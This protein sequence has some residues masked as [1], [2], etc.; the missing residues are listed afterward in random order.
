MIEECIDCAI[1]LEKIKDRNITITLCGHNFHSSCCLEWAFRGNLNCPLCIQPFFES[2]YNN[3]LYN[4]TFTDNSNNETIT[5]S[6]YKKI[7]NDK[8]Y[9]ISNDNDAKVFFT[10]FNDDDFN[11]LDLIGYYDFNSE[12]IIY[13]YDVTRHVV[14]NKI[15]LITNEGDV[16]HYRTH[17][18]IGKYHNIP[19]DEILNILSNSDF[20][21]IIYEENPYFDKECNDSEDFV[22]AGFFYFKGQAYRIDDGQKVDISSVT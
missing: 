12:K 4:Y 8:I 13:K 15:Y 14:N 18:L 11:F 9:F 7:I 10:L 21:K 22:I 20:D 3:N 17:F 16:Y 5:L 6:L 19:I 2:E 1:C